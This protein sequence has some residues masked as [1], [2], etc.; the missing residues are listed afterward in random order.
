MIALKVISLLLCPSRAPTALDIQVFEKG[1]V[2]PFVDRFNMSFSGTYFL[3]NAQ[4]WLGK[5]SLEKIGETR[6]LFLSIEMVA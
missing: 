4:S 1:S 3:P 5:L 6:K 2:S